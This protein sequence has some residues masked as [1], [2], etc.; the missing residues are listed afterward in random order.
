MKD[1]YQKLF[2]IFLKHRIKLQVLA[3]NL[4][5]LIL[6]K[7]ICQTQFG[8]NDDVFLSQVLSG[9][10]GSNGTGYGYINIISGYV[11]KN[12]Y[13]Y[14]PMIPWYIILQYISIF[15]SF[16]IIVYFILCNNS[17]WGGYI[18]SIVFLALMGYECYARVSYYKTAV[19]CSVTAFV[20]LYRLIDAKKKRINIIAFVFLFSIGFLWWEKAPIIG[21]F[22]MLIP[23]FYKFFKSKNKRVNFYLVIT[24]VIAVVLINSLA[25]FNNIYL[26]KHQNI[27]EYVSYLKTWQDINHLGWPDYLE[28]QQKFED[29]AISE[30]TY[31]LLTSNTMTLGY[32]VPL[33]KL[34]EVK[35]I[36]KKSFFNITRFLYFA[37]SYPIHFFDTSLFLGFLIFVFLYS[38]SEKR[39]KWSTGI[40][41]FLI[42]WMMYFFFYMTGTDESSINRIV[43]WIAAIISLLGLTGR[44]TLNSDE[45]KKFY[46]V[47]IITI[48][49]LI[50]N[51]QYENITQILNSD[52]IAN[53][54]GVIKENPSNIYVLENSNS[55][56]NIPFE[57][58]KKGTL[59]NLIMAQN[60]YLIYNSVIMSIENIEN[61]Y[62]L[63]EEYADNM[64]NYL[65]E[66]YSANH[67]TE[68]E[69]TIYD[70]PIF[71][72]KKY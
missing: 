51:Q 32:T 28:N 38:L 58:L 22:F 24:F 48:G 10:F 62:F 33:E 13:H 19:V 26:K 70:L 15:I 42:V 53:I 8:S 3:L 5:C 16:Y 49:L 45:L 37:R 59:G 68:Y 66:M 17:K 63:S 6:F 44:I 34:Q 36:A 71:M 21:M 20:I 7:I 14:I 72:I 25:L 54:E 40:Y 18:S 9:L 41:L 50:I 64:A 31:N 46:S 30:N 65:N 29:L 27:K 2:A 1:K 23:C 55:I 69:G 67:Y 39:R 47:V 12:L 52:S 4:I 60:N 61:V 56:N 35:E 11:L 57:K 43:I